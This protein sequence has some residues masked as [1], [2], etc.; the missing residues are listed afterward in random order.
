MSEGNA[1]IELTSKGQEIMAKMA[2]EQAEATRV[3]TRTELSKEL[4]AIIQEENPNFSLTDVYI[5]AY[6]V[7]LA[8]TTKEKLSEIIE[9]WKAN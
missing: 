7:L 4:E 8:N 1:I 3:P 6:G 9:V 2:S 5:Y